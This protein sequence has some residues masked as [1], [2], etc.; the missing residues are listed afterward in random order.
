MCQYSH[1]HS[2]DY[3]IYRDTHNVLV[4]NYKRK[5]TPYRSPA[6]GSKHKNFV[7]IIVASVDTLLNV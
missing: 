4:E 7:M 6:I 5:K 3:I 2:S 1:L